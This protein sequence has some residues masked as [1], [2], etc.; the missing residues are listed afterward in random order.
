MTLFLLLLLF[1]HNIDF[2]CTLVLIVEAIYSYKEQPIQNEIPNVDYHYT[3][4]PQACHSR[5][6]GLFGRSSKIAPMIF[7]HL[8]VCI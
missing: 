6:V 1:S 5:P 7:N 8:N 3:G 4:L 2:I